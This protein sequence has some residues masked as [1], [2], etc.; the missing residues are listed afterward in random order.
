MVSPIIVVIT[1]MPI[2]VIIVSISYAPCAAR[3][4]SEKAQYKNHLLHEIFL[5]KI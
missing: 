4:E 2:V 5:K 3:S 1:I